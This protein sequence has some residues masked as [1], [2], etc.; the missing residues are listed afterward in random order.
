MCDNISL[1]SVIFYKIDLTKWRMCEMQ[2][3]NNYKVKVYDKNGKT[4]YE[5]M[6]TTMH[7]AEKLYNEICGKDPNI[8]RPTLWKLT[9]D[10]WKGIM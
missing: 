6:C 9:D 7:G 8:P 2:E 3:K 5:V 1:F 4:K 10:G